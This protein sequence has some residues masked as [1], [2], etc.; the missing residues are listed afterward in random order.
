MPPSYWVADGETE[1]IMLHLSPNFGPDFMATSRK[2]GE[3]NPEEHCKKGIK[4]LGWSGRSRQ[5]S[6][7]NRGAT[8]DVEWG[9]LVPLFA[10][11]G[12]CVREV[13]AGNGSVGP[14]C[15]FT[16]AKNPHGPV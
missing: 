1:A 16:G 10:R 13:L 14:G 11:Y 9:G 7:G 2:A 12:A 4:P 3:G 15:D 5:L 8:F 6:A